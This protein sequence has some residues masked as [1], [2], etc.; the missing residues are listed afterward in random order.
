MLPLPDQ[1]GT[2]SSGL[3]IGVFGPIIAIGARLVHASGS[4]R[5]D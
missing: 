3:L 1:T 5:V 2:P 4:L